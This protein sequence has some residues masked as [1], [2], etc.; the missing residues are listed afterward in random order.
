[1]MLNGNVIA[2]AIGTNRLGFASGSDNLMA[3]GTAMYEA[4]AQSTAS[5]RHFPA[6]N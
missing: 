5:I 1:M 6:A 3:A 4:L 2:N